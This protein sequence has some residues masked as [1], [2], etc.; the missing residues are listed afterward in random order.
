MEVRVLMV[1]DSPAL[2]TF[3]RPVL[4]MSGVEQRCRPLDARGGG[5]PG[6]SLE[7]QQAS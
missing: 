4:E 5:I 3:I 6:V 1:D 2:L 7:L